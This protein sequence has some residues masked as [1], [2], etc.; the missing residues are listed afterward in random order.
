M[1]AGG[2]SPSWRTRLL[3]AALVCMAALLPPFTAWAAPGSEA[4]VLLSFKATVKDEAGAL[5]DWAG[6]GP[7]LGGRAGNWTGV[8]CEDGKVIK[9]VLEKMSLSGTLDLDALADL[10][11]LRSI[12]FMN[13]HLEGSLPNVHS[14]SRLRRLY[15]AHN[16][17]SGTIAD[18]SFSG[19]GALRA[20]H[21]EDNAF[22]GP[23]PTSLALAP[24]LIELNLAEN[25]LTGSLPDF[26]QG[27]KLALNV[28][29]NNLE[30]P[31]PASLSRL[32]KSLFQGNDGLCGPPLDNACKAA[33]GA[34]SPTSSNKLSTPLIIAI[35]V[36]AIAVILAIVGAVLVVLRRRQRSE[37][38]QLGRATSYSSKKSSPPVDADRLEQGSAGGS[39]TSGSSRKK[40]AAAAAAARDDQGS[41]LVFV[42][43]E[44]GRFELQDLL[45]A[46]AEVLGS[47][48]FGSSYK[49][50]LLNGPTMVVKRFREMN[51]VGREEFQE[52]MR[53]LGSLSHSNLLPLVAYYY[54]KEEK[55][56][57]TDYIPNGSLA[58][59][60][61][62]GKNSNQ[63]KLDWPERLKIVKGVARGLLHLYSELPMLTT[64]HGHLKSSNV[65]LDESFEPLLSDY[66]LSPV[67]NPAHASEVMVAYRS[68]EY[69]QQGRTT[70]KSDVW[71]LG[72]LILEILTGRFPDN[73]VQRRRGGSNGGG[74]V[75]GGSCGGGGGDLACWVSSM[76]KE[77]WTG[78]VFDGGMGDTRSGGGE[79][80]KLL[81]VG[82][83]CCEADVGRRWEM[84]EAV[85]RI[86][87]LRER[88]DG[89]ISGG[90]GGGG[91]EER[92]WSF[93][94]EAEV[95][96]SAQPGPEEEDNPSFSTATNG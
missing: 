93:A 6:G 20:V 15:L 9:L 95:Y 87:A 10:A 92:S 24:R 71:S 75:G 34:P 41:K 78:E 3:A 85:E 53:R 48:G 66:A 39:S 2:A 47:G 46:S 28:S 4:D 55:L 27:G 21:L 8:Y 60:L 81:Q 67:M 74:S 88:D 5:K 91:E 12:S 36:I 1:S 59:L 26:D 79:M 73:Y 52:H 37:D 32:D 23:I 56:L 62:A 58:H 64:P 89:S 63:P 7:C 49:A 43:E 51:G 57:V 13:N 30:G 69:E 76:L 33:G 84:A 77:E 70:K 82:L 86:E 38:H 72:I 44:R 45:R 35:V 14:L 65:I 17:F 90:G 42:R 11:A 22:T 50:M 94:S 80:L 40:K 25:G 18:D 29:F 96:A 83:A 61:H 31:I 54:R 19:M 68:P 16:K